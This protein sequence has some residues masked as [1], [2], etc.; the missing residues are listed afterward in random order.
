MSCHAMFRRQRD[1]GHDGEGVCKQAMN[2]LGTMSSTV[3]LQAWLTLVRVPKS[4][5]PIRLCY[6]VFCFWR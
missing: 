6:F 5:C 1:S 3:M 2:E 4:A